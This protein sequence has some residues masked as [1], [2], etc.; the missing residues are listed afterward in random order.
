MGGVDV[1]QIVT[2]NGIS[3]VVFRIQESCFNE[4]PTL[5][6][7]RLLKKSNRPG[8]RIKILTEYEISSL[9]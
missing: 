5:H 4:P 3:Y 7:K 6:C 1:G 2:A 9:H 8:K